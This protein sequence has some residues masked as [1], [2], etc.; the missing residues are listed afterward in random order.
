MGEHTKNNKDTPMKTMKKLSAVGLLS[1]VLAACGGN[2]SKVT[3]E[4]TTTDPIFPKIEDATFKQDGSQFGSWPNWD[5]VRQIEKG[6]NKS[7]LYYLVGKPHFK[8][9]FYRVREWDYV[10]NYREH[11]EHKICQFKILFDKNMNV[12]ERF[13]YPES[14][15]ETARTFKP[16][17]L[18]EPPERTKVI[19][20]KESRR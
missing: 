13:W 16:E 20:V 12:N 9:G 10:F 8:E 2:I 1:L 11:G 6:M 4:G 15:A 17:A 19:H 7:Q 14:C 5:N 3:E 18:P